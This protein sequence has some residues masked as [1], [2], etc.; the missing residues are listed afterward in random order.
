MIKVI[1]EKTSD[2]DYDQKRTF[3]SLEECLKTLKE[4]TGTTQFVV[5]AGVDSVLDKHEEYDWE[6]EIY[7]DYRE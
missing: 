4:E 1:V 5:N 7:D 2:W 6:V 3:E